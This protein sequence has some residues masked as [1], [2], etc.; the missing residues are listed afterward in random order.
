VPLYLSPAGRRDP[1]PHSQ[2]SASCPARDLTVELDVRVGDDAPVQPVAAGQADFGTT[3]LK[4]NRDFGWWNG[5]SATPSA[6]CPRST[7][8]ALARCHFIRTQGHQ[9]EE[10]LQAVVGT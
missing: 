3:G 10:T 7:S 2:A 1:C 9:A 4:T 5:S 8:Y 6:T